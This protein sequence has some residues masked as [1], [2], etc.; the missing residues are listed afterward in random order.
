[1]FALLRKIISSSLIVFLLS[2]CVNS[3]P[4]K[5][6][7]VNLNFPESNSYNA[8]IATNGEVVVLIEDERRTLMAYGK[9][10][11][12]NIYYF[13]LPDD[14]KCF[15]TD[16]YAYETLPDGRLQI[17]KDCGS[18]GNGTD[19][20][21]MAYDWETQ[22]L[23]KIAGPLPLGSSG[24]SWNPEQTQA[25]AYLDS[26][27]AT[28]TLYWIYPDHFESLDL[29][30]KDGSRSWNLKDDFPTFDASDKGE[31]GSTGRA[32]WSPDGEQIAFFASPNA[33]G[34]TGF[35]RFSVEY[36]LYL[37]DP[38]TLQYEVVA[39]NIFSPFVLS[40]SPD[41]THIAFIG[42][43]GFW[44]ENGIWLYSI[45]NNK[46]TSISE[47]IYQSIVWKSDTNVAAIQ[48]EELSVCRQMVEF[49][50]SNIIK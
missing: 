27:F 49:D 41:S 50:L 38:E 33:I 14:E 18:G 40:W 20:Y 4:D 6:I 34:E 35:S 9:E 31:S 19:T 3:N 47:G 48:C 24:A 12:K 30:I 2:S 44:K 5:G 26:K 7:P 15:K 22:Q 43:R 1:M 16:Y 28:R 46:V 11:D 21:L 37:L 23:Q 42:K 32:S 45:K 39:N 29:E 17:W 36:Y 25:I 13:P 10:D 8:L